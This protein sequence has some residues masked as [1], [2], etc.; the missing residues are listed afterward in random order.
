LNR[1]QF[2]VVLTALRARVREGEWVEG[3]PLTVSDLAGECGVSPTPVR[4]ALAR[5]AGEGLVEDRRGRGYYARRIDTVELVDLYR[6]Q[7]MLCQ[8]AVESGGCRSPAA[9]QSIVCAPAA[10]LQSPVEAWEGL[11]DAVT[12]RANSPFLVGEQRRL[13]DLLAPARRIEHLVL[14]E[15]ADDV[16]PMTASLAACEWPAFTTALDRLLQRRLAAAEA[17]VTR[18]RLDARK[19][20]VAI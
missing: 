7:Q 19:Y 5:L 20:K 17:L 15:H 16:Q 6:A 18:M 8:A 10:F 3:E 14:G 9:V 2:A 12:R 1:D 11:F 13:A 4:E